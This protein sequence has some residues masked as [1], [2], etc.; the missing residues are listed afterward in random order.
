MDSQAAPSHFNGVHALCAERSLAA[1]PMQM[2]PWAPEYLERTTTTRGGA[3][4]QACQVQ[5]DGC[6][7]TVS[8]HVLCNVALRPIRRTY[9]PAATPIFMCPMLGLFHQGITAFSNSVTWKFPEGCLV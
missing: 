5:N 8:A 2:I 1:V 9:V 7:R 6:S 4:V 3:E